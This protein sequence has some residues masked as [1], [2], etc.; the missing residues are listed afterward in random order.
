MMTLLVRLVLDGLPV[1]P[2]VRGQHVRR[3]AVRAGR[4]NG[5]ATAVGSVVEVMAAETAVVATVVEMEEVATEAVT[6]EGATV[7]ATEVA[8]EAE[9]TEVATV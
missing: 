4:A 3:E 8:T 1:S 9:A 6:V 2:A 7:E 5:M